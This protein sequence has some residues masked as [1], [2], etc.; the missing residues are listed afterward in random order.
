MAEPSWPA[1]EMLPP[2]LDMATADSWAACLEARR[3][4]DLDLDASGVEQVD[5]HGVRTL[6]AAFDT[7]ELD[8][9]RLRVIDPTPVV[10]DIFLCL[11][12]GRNPAG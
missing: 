6:M 10:E 4:S 2:R 1:V 5:G 9:F 3:G 8:G 7:W 12:L 11:D